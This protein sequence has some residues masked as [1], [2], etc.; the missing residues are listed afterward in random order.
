MNKKVLSTAKRNLDKAKAPAKPKDIIY[1]PMGQWKFPG[2]PTRI[3][4]GDITMAGVP[5]PVYGVDNTGYGQM[6]YPDNAYQFPGDVVDEYPQV[7]KKGGTKNSSKYSRSLTATNRLF[8]KNFLHKK[9]KHKIF[10]PN[11]P[12]YQDGGDISIPSLN[13]FQDG[14][15]IIV[16]DLS[17]DQLQ[18]YLDGGYIIERID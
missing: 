2:Q 18:N 11:A 7:A 3:P 13:Q 6:M 5:Y 14:G 16:D 1:D 12:F 17:E 9:H 4:S 8:V 15:E 10:D